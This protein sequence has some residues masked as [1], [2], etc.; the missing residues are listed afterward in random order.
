MIPYY[1]MFLIPA[2]LAIAAQPVSARNVDGTVRG[3]LDGT[4]MVVVAVLTLLIGLRFEVGGDWYNYLAHFNI[5]EGQNYAYVL[6]R[7]E[8]SHWAINKVMFDLGLGLTGVNL[9]YGL[10]FSVGLV[11]F[12]RVQPRPWL[13]IAC[14]VPYLI[15]VVGMGYSRQAVALGFVLLGLVSLRRGRFLRFGI[16]VLAGA[17]FHNSAALLIPVAG[18]TATGSRIK[19]IAMLGLLSFVSYELLLA[20]KLTHLIDVYINR[21]LA[22]SQ[23][24][25]IRLSMNAVAALAFLNFSR[26]FSLTASER[27]L[28]SL[29]SVVAIAMLIIYFITGLSTALDRMALYLIPL[30]LVTVA[31][32]PD[33]FGTTGHKNSGS[34]FAVLTVFFA[35]Q[36]VWLNFASHAN[37]WL[38]Y[39]MGIAQ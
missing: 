29:T 24:A 37:S 20:D 8:F 12:S 3:S 2:M 13:V 31:H 15:T 38:P 11:A 1:F 28:W 30:Q 34:V 19:A 22:S 7:S 35:V 5:M 32:L 23:G 16:L 26:T 18:L 36:L 4:W 33:A 25:L 39:K 14:A 9:F 10:L 6:T 21:Q 17:T 27:L